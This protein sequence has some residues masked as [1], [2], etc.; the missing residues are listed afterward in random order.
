MSG[1]ADKR[2]A[3]GHIKEGFKNVKAT[4]N[5]LYNK[6]G[7]S[8]GA[9]TGANNFKAIATGRTAAGAPIPAGARAKV[10]AM[11]AA[12]VTPIGPIAAF[13]AGVKKSIK[14]KKDDKAM[15]AQVKAIKKEL[16]ADEKASKP[17]KAAPFAA[18]KPGVAR[19]GTAPTIG[20]K[21]PKAPPPPGRPTVMRPANLPK[22][23]SL[24][25]APPKPPP[26]PPAAAPAPRRPAPARKTT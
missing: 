14:E 2:T 11:G 5:A 22:A 26:P 23:S 24:K 7:P 13:A 12:S 20:V 25:V 3:G 8:G 21:L 6:S 19:P 17:P 18:A 15:A 16:R 10:A 9:K 4:Y 1:F